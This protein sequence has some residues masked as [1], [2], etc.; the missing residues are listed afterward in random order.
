METFQSPMREVRKRYTFSEVTIMAWRSREQSAAMAKGYVKPEPGP[1]GSAPVK[2]DGPRRPQVHVQ[3]TED[4]YQLPDNINNGV[5]LP[6]TFFEEEGELNLS[7]V[8]GSQA[9]KYL[10]A[11]GLNIPTIMKF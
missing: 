1:K 7:K 8:K 2:D 11:L 6:K 9:V 5:A 10:N 3:E 4:S